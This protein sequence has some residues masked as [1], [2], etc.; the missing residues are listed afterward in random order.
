MY[1]HFRGHRGHHGHH[2]HHG[3]RRGRHGHHGHRRGRHGHHHGHR[4]RGLLRLLDTHKPILGF[5]PLKHWLPIDQIPVKPL[6][7]FP[8]LGPQLCL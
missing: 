8:T 7:H 5:C 3:H 4:H 1:L 6:Q 2:G